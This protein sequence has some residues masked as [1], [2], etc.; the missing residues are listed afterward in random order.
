MTNE[1]NPRFKAYAVSQ[2]RTPEDQLVHDSE[3]WPGGK[4]AGFTLWVHE[5]WAR[6]SKLFNEKPEWGDNWSDRQIA[7]FDKW[8]AGLIFAPGEKVK[9]VRCIGDVE[10]DLLRWNYTNLT[11]TRMDKTHGYVVVE[12][13]MDGL[14]H[15]HPEALERRSHG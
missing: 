13:G 15:L 2:G 7:Y 14:W 4:M 6:W 8:L 9:I 10:K 3:A 5:Q 12:D 11:V 1:Y